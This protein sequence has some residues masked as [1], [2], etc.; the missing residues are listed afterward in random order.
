MK[1]NNNTPKENKQKNIIK[2]L[3]VCVCTLAKLENKYI[4]QFVQHY[5]RYGVDKIFLYDNN[6]IDG[7]NFEEVINDYIKKGF[8]ELMNWRGENEAMRRIMNDCYIKN[9]K[10][11]DW[12]IFYEIDEFIFLHDFK[13]IKLFLNQKKF[14]KCQE[15]YLNLVCHTDNNLLYYEDKPL[16]ER[17]PLTVPKTKIGGQK[18]EVKTIIR[19]HINGAK[20]MAIHLGDTRLKSC[21]NSGLHENIS[22]YAIYPDQKN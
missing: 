4:R 11:Y 20:I 14:N 21:N 18:L 2:N 3:K 7:E 16:A 6:D 8:V 5:E 12:L 9:Y 19:G 10:Y 22:H 1:I 13:N 17:F 15:I